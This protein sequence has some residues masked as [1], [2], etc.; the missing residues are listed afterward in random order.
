MNHPA[1]T[2][3][4]SRAENLA[5]EQIRAIAESGD[6]SATPL[7]LGT[8]AVNR[9][10]SRSVRCT[11]ARGAYRFVVYATDRAGNTQSVAGSDR[12]TVR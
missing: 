6:K 5:P 8:C 3:L 11:L 9:A 10:P 4:R 2:E 1:V 12:L 7:R